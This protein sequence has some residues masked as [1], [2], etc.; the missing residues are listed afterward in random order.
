VADDDQTP[1]SEEWRSGGM[2]NDDCS[3]ISQRESQRVA[4]AG[5]HAE[6]RIENAE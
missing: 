6:C 1:R 5:W 2:G 4:M 3:G